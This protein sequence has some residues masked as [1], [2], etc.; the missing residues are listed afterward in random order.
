MKEC[1]CKGKISECDHSKHGVVTSFGEVRDLSG[2]VV[3]KN[4]DASWSCCGCGMPL[5]W[6]EPKKDVAAE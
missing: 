6:V 5:R 3:Y 2:R 1:N 4:A